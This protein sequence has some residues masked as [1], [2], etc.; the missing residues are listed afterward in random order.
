MTQ[1]LRDPA[2]LAYQMLASGR[3]NV[4]NVGGKRKA[5]GDVTYVGN[6]V[7]GNT[8][9]VN[10]VVFTARAAGAVGNEFNIAGSLT[11][12]LDALAA[13]LNASVVAAVAKAT[14]ANVGGTKLGI[15][16]D[17]YGTEGN[18][19]TL[20][21]SVGTVSGAVLAGGDDGDKIDIEQNGVLMLDT[22]AGS[23]E[24][25]VLP[26]GEEGQLVTIYL[27][28]KG[29][30]S[31][32]VVAGTFG[33]GTAATFDAAGDFIVLQWLNGAWRTIVASSVTIA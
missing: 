20:A 25:F 24:D 11:L 23:N 26:S 8:I 21:A 16:F 13:V 22:A 31:N 30:G 18:A 4:Q 2:P 14:Y 6:F 27:K 29:A 9:T 28:T 33:A 19:F 12:S 17:A 7:A 10:G 5:T 3:R 1:W 32:A 15:T